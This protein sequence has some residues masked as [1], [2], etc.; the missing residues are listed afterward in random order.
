MDAGTEKQ[1]SQNEAFQKWLTSLGA[2]L[3]SFGAKGEKYDPVN[4]QTAKG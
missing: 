2:H 1:L 4:R 3:F